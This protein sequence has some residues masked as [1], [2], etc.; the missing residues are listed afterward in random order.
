MKNAYLI[1]TDLHYNVNKEH[2]K[3]YLGE[4]LQVLTQIADIRETYLSRG[5]RVYLIF[6]GDVIDGS[7]QQ[8][9]DAMRCQNLFRYYSSLFEEVYVVLGNHEANNVK[10]N[11]FWFLVS[12][13][14]D[15]ALKSINKALQPQ[16]LDTVFRLPD[17]ISDGEVTFYFNHFG[18]E[19]KVPD[20]EGVS[21][22]LF[23]QNIGSEKICKMWSNYI[24]VED[25]AFVQAYRY[26]F[27]GHLHLGGGQ[28][29]LNKDRTCIG[30]WL[31]TCIGTNVTE[32]ETLPTECKIPAVLVEDGK[33]IEIEENFI[34]R[35]DPK[36]AID[37]VKL[38]AT[39]A[40][41]EMI[42]AVKNMV[43]G[44]PIGGTLYQR[45]KDAADD[46]K[47]GSLVELLLE[48]PDHI[49]YE[50]KRG[51]ETFV[52]E[53]ESNGRSSECSVQETE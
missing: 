4:V 5:Y 35:S 16:G 46:V 21:I 30:E 23:H 42:S 40:T 41:N 28:Y 20:A 3:N 9:E 14:E 22:G 12:D 17:K 10:S 45:I 53:A 34:K 13:L 24:D 31:G 18:I 51:M 37:Y 44:E 38:K 27:F 15:E 33:F 26:L 43:V 1:V 8:A 48:S 6:L 36:Q 11:P 7:I 29:F 32:V 50:Y 52:L 25:A 47:L 19:P 49:K 39:R 2:R